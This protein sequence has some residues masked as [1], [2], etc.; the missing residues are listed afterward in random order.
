VKAEMEAATA[1]VG[2]PKTL[3]RTYWSAHQRF[4]KEMCICSKVDEVVK[5][6][7]Q[8]LKDNNHAI[9]I[10]LQSVSLNFQ[11]CGLICF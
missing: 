10:G 9:V 5:Q 1:E 6:A 3:W 11:A 4:F 2:S 7:K 8:Y